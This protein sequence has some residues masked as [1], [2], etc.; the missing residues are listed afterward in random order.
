MALGRYTRPEENLPLIHLPRFGDARGAQVPPGAP[1]TGHPAPGA[2]DPSVRRLAELC[3]AKWDNRLRAESDKGLVSRVKEAVD[4]IVAVVAGVK[5]ALDKWP[6]LFGG[7]ARVDAAGKV[8][9]VVGVAS[10]LHSQYTSS[11]ATTTVGKVVDA[12]AA[13]IA[14]E[15]LTKRFPVVA[16]VD[17]GITIGFP[18]ALGIESKRFTI[19]DNVCTRVHVA[20]AYGEAIVSGDMTSLANY[21]ERAAKGEYGPPAQVVVEMG[22]NTA[23]YWAQ[24]GVLGGLANVKYLF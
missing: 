5:G 12:G 17:A 4:P 9:T 3:R 11:P 14:N 13:A 7:S 24:H 22:Q 18:T 19:P 15:L 23:N 1:G 16:V 2:G 8:A 20:V 10:T 21:Q 6:R